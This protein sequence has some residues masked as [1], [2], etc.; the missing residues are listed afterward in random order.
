MTTSV[1]RDQ[2]VGRDVEQYAVPVSAV[3]HGHAHH[4]APEGRTSASVPVY[5]VSLPL[6]QRPQPGSLS[7]S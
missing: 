5:N 7:E 4:G 1:L 3:F 2:R 6:L